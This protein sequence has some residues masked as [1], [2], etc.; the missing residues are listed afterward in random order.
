MDSNAAIIFNLTEN[1]LYNSLSSSTKSSQALKRVKSYSASKTEE[2][3]KVIRK[4]VTE[5]NYRENQESGQDKISRKCKKLFKKGASPE[6]LTKLGESLIGQ[7]EYYNSYVQY[8]L[9]ALKREIT[10]SKELNLMEKTE[11]EQI[12]MKLIT[13]DA[14][15]KNS[16]ESYSS[17]ETDE[18]S[19]N[20]TSNTL[21]CTAEDSESGN[22]REKTNLK[23]WEN[24]PSLKDDNQFN[25]EEKLPETIDTLE[26]EISASELNSGGVDGGVS[27]PGL[28]KEGLESP[29]SSGRS[30]VSLILSSAGEDNSVQKEE[31]ENQI[32]L[33]R[34]AEEELQVQENK[35]PSNGISSVQAPEKKRNVE[36]TTMQKLL[37]K[38]KKGE[39]ALSKG[40]LNNRELYGAFAAS[41]ALLAIVCFVGAVV[42]KSGALCLGWYVMTV[43]LA[44]AAVAAWYLSLL[45]SSKL[46]CANSS[47]VV[48]NEKSLRHV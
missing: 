11:I 8:F 38:K 18:Q 42:T 19:A 27:S 4:K 10:K 15:C 37:M 5:E 46:A 44:I 23:H 25:F 40:Q 48:N 26:P 28:S 36:G 12:I 41:C 3:C 16:H 7:E 34:T 43:V 47:P 17:T 20:G 14:V 21:S 13:S 35:R 2:L 31:S 33:E 39:D 29:V 22:T 45:P 24:S 30:S 9:P 6:V 32:K 1:N